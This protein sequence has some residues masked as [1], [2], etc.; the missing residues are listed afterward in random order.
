MIVEYFF[1]V[2]MKDIISILLAIVTLIATICIPLQIMKFQRYTAL[3][4]TYESFEF[5]HALQSVIDF[6]YIDCNCDVEQI[7]VEYKKRFNYDFDILKR[8][9]EKF[10]I[11]NILH[12][13]RRLLNDYFMELEMC[14]ESSRVLRNIIRKDWTTSEAWVCKI[15]V[16]M[17]KAV[18]NDPELFKDISVIKYERMPRVKGLSE[19]LARFYNALRKESRN[20]QL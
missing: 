15:L 4:S 6:Y 2:Q 16:F 7:P 13:Q 17:N 14:R 20:M 10:D 5:A 1:D 19:Y 9:R 3:M 11:S 18:D 8:N 12:Y